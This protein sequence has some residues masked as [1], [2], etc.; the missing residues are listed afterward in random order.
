MK[1]REKNF[2][3]CCSLFRENLLLLAK[4][5]TVKLIGAVLLVAES[6]NVKMSKEKVGVVVKLFFYVV[7]IVC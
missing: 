2:S 4:L 6:E 3:L 1:W 7:C 5:A